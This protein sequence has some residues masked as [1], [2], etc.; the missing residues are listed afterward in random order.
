MLSM[1]YPFFNSPDDL[2]ALVEIAALCGSKQVQ[3]MASSLSRKVSF[4]IDFP[5]SNLKFLCTK[6][7]F[8]LLLLFFSFIYYISYFFLLL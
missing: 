3:D 4:P 2:S 1:R 7:V 8:L 5:Q 6:Y